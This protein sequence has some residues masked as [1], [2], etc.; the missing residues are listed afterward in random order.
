M[1]VCSI[2]SGVDSRLSRQSIRSKPFR[3]TPKCCRRLCRHG[4]TD[5]RSTRDTCGR[6]GDMSRADGVLP[7]RAQ[8]AKTC[9]SWLQNMAGL[10]RHGN[11]D[12]DLLTG[13]LGFA[14]IPSEFSCFVFRDGMSMYLGHAD[15][16]PWARQAV[17]PQAWSPASCACRAPETPEC[18]LLTAEP[19][20]WKSSF[21][22]SARVSVGSRLR[23][24]S[25]GSFIRTVALSGMLLVRKT[26][27]PMT[28]PSPMTVSPPR[29]VALA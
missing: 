15:A 21:Q 13:A 24:V 18:H 20:I 23:T 10:G 19:Q 4:R 22:G 14:H 17:E 11:L 6:S 8:V 26:D 25:S 27:A 7:G 2:G 28:A 29:T 16:E 3:E 9:Q 1:P 12:T 5:R